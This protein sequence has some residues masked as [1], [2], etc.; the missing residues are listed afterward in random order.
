MQISVGWGGDG[1]VGGVGMEEWVGCGV[2]GVGMEEWVG[3]GWRGG[4]VGLEYTQRQLVHK[5][6]NCFRVMFH[7]KYT[8]Q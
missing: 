5:P 3:W 8:C 1:G 2:W 6:M 4:W 7:S